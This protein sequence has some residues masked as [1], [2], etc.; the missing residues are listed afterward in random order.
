MILKTNFQIHT[1][2]QQNKRCK[3]FMVESSKSTLDN[4]VVFPLK[5]RHS[6]KSLKSL[7]FLYE[8][9]SKT[10]DNKQ[11]L[12]C[13]PNMFMKVGS[14]LGLKRFPGQTEFGDP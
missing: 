7:H 8:R 6:L 5:G 3:L 4:T 14:D 13:L 2:I 10:Q 1:N 11:Q 12:H 9:L